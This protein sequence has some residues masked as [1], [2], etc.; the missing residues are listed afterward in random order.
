MR[1][2][3]IRLFLVFAAT[4]V[5]LGAVEVLVRVFWNKLSGPAVIPLTLKTHRFS[6]NPVT[7]YE[8]VPGSV[9]FE[10]NA[11]YRINRDGIRDGDYPRTKP[12]G[13]YRIAV[14]GDSCTFGLGL[15][16]GDTWPKQLERE[17]QSTN[18]HLEVIN[19]GVMGYNTPQEAE[20]IQDKVLGYSPDLIII[21]YSLNDIGVLSRER[22]V[23][24][25]YKGYSSFLTTG[26][27]F[28]DKLLP[29]FK[30]YLLMKNRLFLKKT[31][32]DTRPQYS[33]DGLK[34][35]KKGYDRYF[36]DAYQEAENWNIL[37]AAFA[38]IRSL[39]QP[40]IPVLFVIHPELQ[41]M[42]HY[43]FTEIHEIVK[44]LCLDYGFLVLDPLAEMLSYKARD[45][46][47]S[48]ANVHPN[49]LGNKIF[50][51]AIA[52]YLQTASLVK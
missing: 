19:F 11:W 46:R 17:L 32:A 25:T 33:K 52:R 21:G 51:Q 36:F 22:T 10:D 43:L 14:L 7:G 13:T 30:T 1:R 18:P 42:D 39:T 4:A 44:K 35:L 49:S 41:E 3:F 2:L 24:S 8:L 45:L 15:E 29:H 20:R 40:Q 28:V 26:I 38:K 31:N 5:T 23:L 9:A 34:F 27:G 50:A 16:L 37:N 6:A 48:A 12:N 47:I